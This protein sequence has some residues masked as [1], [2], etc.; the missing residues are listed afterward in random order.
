MAVLFPR[1]FD[2]L[3]R[4]L[5]MCIVLG[6]V[7][8]PALLMAWVRSP[9]H[10][11][12]GKSVAQPIQ[13]DH[14]H[15]VRDAGIDCFFC[16][17]DAERSASAGM[18]DTATCMGCH[19]QI[20]IDSPELE[21]VRRSYYKSEPIVWRRVHDLPDFVFFNHAAHVKQGVGCESCH[22]RVDLMANVQKVESL[23]MG[24][25]LDCHRNPEPHLRP[26]EKV[27]TMGYQPS[28][29]RTKLGARLAERLGITP[30]THCTGCHR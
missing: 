12:Q 9:L 23:N 27:T 29:P 22:G 24:W 14:R 25:C 8:I 6:I 5:L 21:P 11:G 15:H 28:E 7:G 10:T 13:F 30:P 2:D 3:F 1:W 20:W 4:L 26:A 17:Y 19:A 18:P 16:H